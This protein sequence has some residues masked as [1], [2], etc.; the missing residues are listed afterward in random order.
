MGLS[1]ADL[2]AF[3][4]ASCLRQGVPV[5]VTDAAVVARVVA[6]LGVGVAGRKRS[7]TAAPA[8]SELPDEFDAVGVEA[9]S[10]G[11]A[12]S[13]YGVVEDGSDDGGLA[14]QVEFGPPAA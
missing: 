12:G 9:S 13:D 14:G 6:L 7:G 2:A 8:A 11:G 1:P 5:R 3:V 10:T 4:E